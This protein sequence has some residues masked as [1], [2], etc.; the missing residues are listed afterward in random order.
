MDANKNTKII[1]PELS[2]KITG[3]LFKVHNELGNRYHEKYYQRAIESEL[4][5]NN[6]KFIKE[7]SVDL[8]YNGEKIGKYRLDF[9][10]ENRIILEIKAVPRLSVSDFK[11][12]TAYLRSK[13]IKLGILANFRTDKLISK[14]IL[15]SQVNYSH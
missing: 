7:L 6:I 15:N 9:F 12:V 2:Y 4:I 8:T 13:K 10:I 5:A 14:R 3:I 11:Q 1:Y